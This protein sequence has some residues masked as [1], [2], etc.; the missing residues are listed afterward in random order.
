MNFNASKFLNLPD[1]TIPSGNSNYTISWRINSYPGSYGL[2]FF[3]GNP[4][5]QSALPSV[6]ALRINGTEY[7]N[8]WADGI[9]IFKNNLNSYIANSYNSLVYNNSSQ[10]ISLYA[11]SSTITSSIPTITQGV[12]QSGT[13]NNMIG[14]GS[15]YADGQYFN[16]KLHSISFCNSV[17]SD[18]DRIAIQGI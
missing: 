11:N 4:L 18:A 9:G 2:L 7:W 15:G 3:S 6:N 16:G 5:L 12:R 17:L 8:L 10:T 14:N 13:L 1:D